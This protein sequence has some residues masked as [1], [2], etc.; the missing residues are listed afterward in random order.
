[1]TFRKRNQYLANG[2]NGIQKAKLAMITAY[3][4]FIVK[5]ANEKYENVTAILKMA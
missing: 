5:M 1:M 2:V 4:Q 3:Q